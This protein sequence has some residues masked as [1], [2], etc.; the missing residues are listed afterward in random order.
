MGSHNFRLETPPNIRNVFHVDKLRAVSKDP[1]PSQASNNN[2]PNP[3]IINNENNTHEYD[4][5]KILK[6]KKRSRLPTSGEMEKL[7][8]PYLGTIDEFE[9]NL[10][11]KRGNVMG[12]TH[13]V[14]GLVVGLKKVGL[15]SVNWLT[16]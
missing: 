7:Y 6:K 1:L 2:H 4:V 5:E 8:S 14:V 15:T 16:R 11:W 13:M 10:N 3:S 9:T 12:W